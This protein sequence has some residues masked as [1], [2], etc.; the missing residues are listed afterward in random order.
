MAVEARRPKYA[1]RHL[2]SFCLYFDFGGFL[3][4]V[5]VCSLEVCR[6][7]VPFSMLVWR[8]ASRDRRPCPSPIVTAR[9]ST[10]GQAGTCSCPACAIGFMFTGCRFY[11]VR[12]H[13]LK[14][15]DFQ[16]QGFCVYEITLKLKGFGFKGSDRVQLFGFAVYSFIG[17]RKAA[18]FA[19]LDQN[20]ELAISVLPTAINQSVIIYV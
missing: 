7:F 12:F 1:L 5:R 15:Q 17:R 9:T 11:N 19:A 14:V 16:F 3:Q 2:L 10:N 4:Q 18:S 8:K 6:A 20:R 13:D